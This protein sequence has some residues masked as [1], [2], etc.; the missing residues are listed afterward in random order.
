[1]ELDSIEAQ[2]SREAQEFFYAQRSIQEVELQAVA[3]EKPFQLIDPGQKFSS[4]GGVQLRDRA[5]ARCRSAQEIFESGLK[6]HLKS[7]EVVTRH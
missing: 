1:M 4:E 6:S 5:P 3:I 2:I 7:Y